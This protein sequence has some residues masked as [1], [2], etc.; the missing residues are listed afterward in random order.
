MH[1]RHPEDVRIHVVRTTRTRESRR[2]R[3][4]ARPQVHEVINAEGQASLW[5]VRSTPRIALAEDRECPI[6]VS[7]LLL[8]K[9]SRRIIEVLV[10]K[11]FNRAVDEGCASIRPC[12]FRDE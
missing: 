5:K 2:E 9:S 11:A 8:R 12:I 10:Q 3:L 6:L 4:T 1:K 7:R